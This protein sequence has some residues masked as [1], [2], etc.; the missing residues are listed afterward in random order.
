MLVDLIVL[1]F[2]F[3]NAASD[4]CKSLPEEVRPVGRC[5]EDVSCAEYLAEE[6]GG[7]DDELVDGAGGAPEA[8]RGD[9]VEVE[10]GQPGV[11]TRVDTHH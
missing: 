11:Q 9:L 6:D 7:G 4:V 3:H 2:P 1:C 5:A 8:A 10:R